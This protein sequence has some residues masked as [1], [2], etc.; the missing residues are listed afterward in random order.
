MQSKTQSCKRQSSGFRLTEQRFIARINP[1]LS[2]RALSSTAASCEWCINILI[3]TISLWN[4]ST[5]QAFRWRNLKNKVRISYKGKNNTIK[6]HRIIRWFFTTIITTRETLGIH[7]LFKGMLPARCR[8]IESFANRLL[9]TGSHSSVC[10]F[11][12]KPFRP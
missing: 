8:R 5:K 6:N 11:S 2:A 12:V 9:F 3:R 1:A 10:L 4:F 7:Q